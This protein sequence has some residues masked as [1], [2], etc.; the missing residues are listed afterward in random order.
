MLPRR[1]PRAS[2]LCRLRP[3]RPIQPFTQ[4]TA[5]MAGRVHRVTMFK[6]PSKEDQDKLLN[7]YKILGAEQQKVD[8][9]NTTQQEEHL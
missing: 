8:R 7:Q 3:I 1:L 2:I 4:N 5:E 9:A 6:L